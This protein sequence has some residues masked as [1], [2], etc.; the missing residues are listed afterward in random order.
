MRVARRLSGLLA[1]V[2][3]V[4]A[5]LLA[6]T[7]P[8]AIEITAPRPGQSLT[9]GSRLEIAWREAQGVASDFEEWEA[10]L[11]LDGGAT[12]PYRLTPHLDRRLDRFEVELPPVASARARL[13]LR[14]GDEHDERELLVPFE[15]QIVAPTRPEP[16]EPAASGW[17]L[18]S[19]ES[20]RPGLAGVV[21][22]VEGERDG[23]RLERRRELPASGFGAPAAIAAAGDAQPALVQRSPRDE[24]RAAARDE[25]PQP[26]RRASE[27]TNP[28]GPAPGLPV[29]VRLSRLSRWNE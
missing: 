15:L 9:A 10:F 29:S 25:S 17:S 28:A 23:A 2:S 5:P 1:L 7:P 22:W 24:L 6:A 18:R 27:R 19:G 14:F 12:F 11:S 21:D 4:A 13:M 16:P 26:E 20:A 3:G 8:A